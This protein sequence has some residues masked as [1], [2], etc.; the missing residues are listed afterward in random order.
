MLIPCSPGEMSPSWLTTVLR[1]SGVLASGAVAKVDSHPLAGPE[2]LYGQI[3]RLTITYDGAEPTAPQ[4]LIAKLSSADARMRQRPNTIASYEREV[5]FYQEIAPLSPVPVATCYYAKVDPLSGWHVILLQDLAP[6]RSGSRADG[7]TQTEAKATVNHICRFHALWWE[8]PRLKAFEG[9]REF[10]LSTDGNAWADAHREWWPAFVGKLG[11]ELPDSVA[12]VGKLLGE[13]RESIVR[14]LFDRPPLTLIH[15]DFHLDNLLFGE[16][17]ES[18]FIVDW[19]FIKLGHGVWDVA[20]FLSQNL[21]PADRR[22]IEMDLLAMYVRVLSDRGHTGYSLDDAL[23]DYRLSL[24]HRF[25]QLIST[26]AA[27]PFTPEQIRFH[28]DILLPRAVAALLDHDCLALL[29]EHP[30]C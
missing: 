6:A 16:L 30:G 2:G 24:L 23:G 10:A 19:Q 26:I 3:V 27:M 12:R 8:S 1:D 11:Y 9:L 14:K 17:P 20:Y 28:V 13:H 18:I 5:Q 15:G 7:C 4:T 22:A 21:S 29:E 25:G